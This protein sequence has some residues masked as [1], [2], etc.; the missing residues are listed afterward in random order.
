MS[1]RRRRTA[2]FAAPP[3]SKSACKGV[4]RSTGIASGGIEGSGDV[5]VPGD[6]VERSGEEAPPGDGREVIPGQ[7]SGDKS[8]SLPVGNQW[9]R[10]RPATPRRR[11]STPRTPSGG[12]RRR[13]GTRAHRTAV[14]PATKDAG[15]LAHRGR[16]RN[17]RSPAPH[18]Q[19]FKIQN[20][21]LPKKK[22]G[23]IKLSQGLM[24]I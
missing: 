1:R 7:A 15:G 21:A 17:A 18:F 14:R 16:R 24:P 4:V 9:S 22:K 23:I 20:Q 5:V 6:E 13:T 3:G 10:Q 12:P 19:E 11:L 2:C 8:D